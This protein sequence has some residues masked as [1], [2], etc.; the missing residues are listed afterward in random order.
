MADNVFV[1]NLLIE[2]RGRVVSSVMTYI[3][4]EVFP[5]LRPEQRKALRTKMLSSIGAY[6]DVCLDILKA[7]INDGTVT[8]ERVLELLQQIHQEVIDRG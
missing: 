6:H 7:S 8:N 3:E 4:A 1:R 2:Q 5:V